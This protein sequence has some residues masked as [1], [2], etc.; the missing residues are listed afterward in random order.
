MSD[1][2]I[3]DNYIRPKIH[4]SSVTIVLIGKDTG[5]RWWI[6]WEIYYSMLKTSGNEKNGVLG[7]LLPNKE[8]N[9]PKRLL[10]NR[11]YC[12]IISM[13]NSKQELERAIERA[14][15]KRYSM[16]DL[17]SPLRKRK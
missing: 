16:P 2:T 10:K 7:I 15:N 5:G 6:D 14:Y 1:D 9:I 3:K 17:S 12:E 4:Q 8:H 11:D 13:P